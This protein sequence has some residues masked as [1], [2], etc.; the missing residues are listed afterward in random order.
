MDSRTR[1]LVIFVLS[2]ASNLRCNMIIYEQ[3]KFINCRYL[4]ESGHSSNNTR[5]SHNIGRLGNL[6]RV[7]N[8]PFLFLFGGIL[9]AITYLKSSPVFASLVS[10]PS[11]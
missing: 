11:I 8:W 2:A 6:V 10:D 5:A 9:F 3:D 1:I 7:T 4:E